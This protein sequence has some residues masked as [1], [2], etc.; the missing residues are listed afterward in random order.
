MSTMMLQLQP[1][2]DYLRSR[3]LSAF[4]VDAIV[5][6]AMQD[7]EDQMSHKQDEAIDRLV[8]TGMQKGSVDFINDLRPSDEDFVL[9][10]ESGRTDFSLPPY[11]NLKNL[12]KNPKV[13][14]DGTQYKVIPV[15]APSAPKT[16]AKSIFDVTRSMDV[17][18][19]EN[20]AA[21]S[22]VPAGT[23]TS[24]RTATSKQDST[25]KWVLP[26]KKMDFT[27]DLNQVNSELR[28]SVESIVAS[29]IKSYKGNY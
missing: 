11:P 10:T 17:E 6:Q 28:E 24:F 9:E 7:I 23:K 18:R 12:L 14:K 13:A 20:A 4:E 16:M 26:A 15:G 21:Q 1:L 3:G 2:K 22:K 29:V 8:D 5:Q 19:K 27:D 25:T